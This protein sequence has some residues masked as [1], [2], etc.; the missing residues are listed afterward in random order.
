MVHIALKEGETVSFFSLFS[1]RLSLCACIGVVQF[2]KV[3][4]ETQVDLAT[5]RRATYGICKKSV[6]TVNVKKYIGCASVQTVSFRRACQSW[7][8]SPLKRWSVEDR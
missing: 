5:G 6:Y 7:A 8:Q 2:L 4:A 1:C 3:F